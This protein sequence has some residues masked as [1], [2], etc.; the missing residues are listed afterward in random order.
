MMH[1]TDVSH[2]FLDE[3]IGNNDEVKKRCLSSLD[4]GGE[5]GNENNDVPLY[6]Q[7]NRGLVLTQ[8]G[9]ERTNLQLEG[10]ERC[11]LTGYIPSAE[12]GLMMGA[13]PKPKGILMALGEPEEEEIEMSKKRRGITR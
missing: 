5:L 4:L 2:A 13:M 6:D 8:Q 9:R 7:F 1:P 3:F 11:G 12:E 10:G